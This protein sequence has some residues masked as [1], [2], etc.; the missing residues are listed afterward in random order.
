LR[1]LRARAGLSQEA[2]AERAGLGPA[3]VRALE[4]DQRPRPHPHT[5]ALLAEAL[6]LAPAERAAL[7]ELASGVA[8]QPTATG[9]PAAAAPRSAGLVRLPVPP[10]PLIGREA[11]L[12][13]L[14]VLLD[15]VAVATRLLTLVGPGG[16]GKT[17]L[18]VAVAG[19]LVT[20]FP[21]GVVFVDLAP[22]REARLVPATI[23]RALDVRESGGRSA[24]ALLLEYLRE[25]RVLLVLDNFEHLL[26][27][28][29]LAPE[30]LGAC[31]ALAL[32]VTSRAA[33][34]V[35]AERRFVVAPLAAPG[36]EADAA[37][38]D[39]GASPAVRLFVERA[40]LVAPGFA[41]DGDTAAAIAGI[42]RRMDGIPLALELAA[43]RVRLLPPAALLRRLERRLGPHATDA[44]ALNPRRVGALP[45]LVGGAP[46]LPERQQT[47]RATLAWSHDLLAPAAQVLFRRLA[48]FAGGWTL[49]AAEAVCASAE[50]TAGEVLDRLHVLVDSSLVQVRRLEDAGGEPRFGLLE[51]VREYALE[52]LESAG[53]GDELAGR[54]AAYFLALSERA[55]PHLMSAEQAAWLD[56]L[57]GELGNLRAALA[58][59]RNG[60][61][62][63]LG[64][65]LAVA[66]LR[67]WHMRGHGR[68]GREWLESLR[69][70][71]TESDEPPHLAALHA[72]ALG[73]TGWITYLQ[74]DHRTAGPLAEQCLARWRRLGQVGN[75]PVA[76]TTLAF[77][78]GHEGDVPRQ[79]ALFR[80]SLALYRA[81]G[82]IRG[83]AWVLAWLGT[84]RISADDLDGAEALLAEGLAVFEERGDTN[85]VA[86][87]WQHLGNVAAA[88]H[89]YER[90]QALL[91]RSLTLNSEVL[92]AG[93]GVAYV[94]GALAG[95]AACRAELGRAR[96]LCE[97]SVGRFRQLGS[98]RG[99]AAHLGLLGR[100]AALQ[101]DDAAAAVAHAECLRLSL[102]LAKVDLVFVL[103]WLAEARGR[104]AARAAARDRLL[105]AVRLS[106]TAAA[107]RDRLGTA[108]S[109]S[110][111]IPWVPPK[112]DAS[113]QQMAAIRDALG[114]QAFQAAWAEGR[115]RLLEEAI[116][117]AL[118]AAPDGA[119]ASPRYLEH[120]AATARF[121]LAT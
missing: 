15:P 69:R 58:W 54:H 66:L 48:V 114:E 97:E 93:D 74:G 22:L 121:E 77:V 43:A 106:G 25:R 83:A 72:R 86:L 36:A 57:D 29:P 16:V 75:S 101:G 3:T 110:W 5:L 96:A 68:E 53:E 95:L 59:A 84:V 90:A 111:A 51:T 37:E 50:L 81:E 20:D 76:L 88:R 40:R 24:R 98:T 120:P 55:E 67:F 99:L 33:L 73:T 2:L 23:A 60:D 46:D 18:G 8:A 52:Q 100:L 62:L 27:A 70:G 87:A 113:A 85:G 7:L 105:A 26:E 21:D 14:K 80:Q 63:E 109:R 118:A 13:Q 44:P 65:R 115:R 47:L 31:P 117:A 45:L 19:D 12:S 42:C 10:T 41:L 30:L 71:V 11:E 103:E 39:V 61:R 102:S 4:R 35:Q 78:A 94:L 92:S 38:H 107:L 56:R 104:A 82:D 49:E 9:S 89:D 64:L 119:E 116:A 112:P 28:A 108:A 79:E 32:L 91:E 17:R 6:G 34:R 1:G